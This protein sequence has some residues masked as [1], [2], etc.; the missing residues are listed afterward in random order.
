MRHVFANAALIGAQDMH[1]RDLVVEGGCIADIVAAGDGTGDT[2]EDLGGQIVSPPMFDVQVN[3]GGGLMLGACRDVADLR[4]MAEAHLHDGVPHILPTLI[5]DTAAEI[6][7]IADLIEEA[8][9]AGLWQ[10]RGLHLE[11]P[12]LTRPGAHDPAMLRP[13]TDDDL[14]LYARVKGQVGRLK[15][16][17]APELVPPERIAA[18]CA[19]GIIVALGHS[20]CDSATARTAFDAGAVAAT[21]LFNAMSGL[22]HRAPGLALAALERG[23]FG[24]IADGVH[25]HPDMLR[26]AAR[27]G[28]AAYLVSDAMAVAG[29]DHAVFALGGRRITRQ[30]GR[31]TLEDG[32]LAGADLTLA[33][34]VAVMEA[35]TALPRDAVIRMATTT[36]RALMGIA[37]D[38]APGD[39][40]VFHAWPEGAA[41]RLHLLEGWQQA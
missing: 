16:T 13:L 27:H 3:G 41:P 23:S 24:L 15:L 25:V 6:A 22:D 38:L 34:A 29:T 19:E 40:A 11:G 4:A 5:S 1:W 32:T 18:L 2:R 26:L 33:R 37:P 12:H 31:L 28:A 36:P 9:R 30:D 21:H 17:I 14:A 8:R 7:R 20:G 39:P 35:A 10:I